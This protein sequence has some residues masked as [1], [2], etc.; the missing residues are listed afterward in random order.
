MARNLVLKEDTP[1][2]KSLIISSMTNKA[3]D[4]FL[5]IKYKMYM[6]KEIRVRTNSAKDRQKHLRM[7]KSVAN[8]VVTKIEGYH[9]DNLEYIASNLKNRGIEPVYSFFDID[10]LTL[11]LTDYKDGLVAKVE[12]HSEHYDKD[13]ANAEEDVRILREKGVHINSDID[14]AASHILRIN[15][16]TRHIEA[17]SYDRTLDKI[18][19]HKGK[20]FK[21]F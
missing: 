7:L 8:P 4:Y 2:R 1:K 14:T 13:K 6:G 18:Y 21:L 9:D 12:L 3:I 19:G 17:Y 5:P 11:Y 16:N 15:K 20:Q 10:N